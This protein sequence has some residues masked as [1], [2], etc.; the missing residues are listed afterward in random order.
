MDVKRIAL[1]G[2]VF[3]GLA[4]LVAGAATS[5][6]RRIDPVPAPATTAID[7][8]GAALASEVARLHERL[9]PGVV[10]QQPVRNLFQFHQARSTAPAAIDAPPPAQPVVER[11]PP[12]PPFKLIGVAE[13]Q[14]ESGVLMRTAIIVGAGEM[15][16]VKEGEAVT[17]RY[18]VAK[19]SGDAV[20]LSDAAGGV[21]V[22][23]A[24][25]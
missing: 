22:R 3:G 21:S 14:G 1:I 8:S 19:I 2:A 17:G 15:F 23:L 7:I 13:D 16:L 6:V 18:H 24:L 20:E 10:P 12:P 4:A 5:G 25:K 9:K 11:G